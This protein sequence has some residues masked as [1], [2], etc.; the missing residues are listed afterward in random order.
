MNLASRS[1]RRRMSLT[2]MIDVVFLLLVFFMLAARFGTEGGIALAVPGEA[3]EQSGP[4]RL[5]D[6]YPTRVTLNGV[7]LRPDALIE[8]L[9]GL[10]SGVGEPVILR[11][12]G[13]ANVQRV[14]DVAESLK[15]GGLDNL[16]LTE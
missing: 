1:L 5:V 8:T 10:V 2:P 4:P 3:I 9:D 16:A 15:R 14:I 7:S 12:R 6:V 11:A 13:G